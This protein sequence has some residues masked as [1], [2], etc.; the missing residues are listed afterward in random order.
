ME[1]T[2]TSSMQTTSSTESDFDEDRSLSQWGEGEHKRPSA[3]YQR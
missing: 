2:E 1:I 3:M